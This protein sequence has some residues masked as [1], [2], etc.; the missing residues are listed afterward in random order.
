MAFVMLV[1][2]H[3]KMHK[4]N[5]ALKIVKTAATIVLGSSRPH[6]AIER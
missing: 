2:G 5:A 3:E 1:V 6:M 4:V